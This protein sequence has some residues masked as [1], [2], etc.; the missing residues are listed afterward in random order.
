LPLEGYEHLEYL[1]EAITDGWDSWIPVSGTT[2]TN[3]VVGR[4]T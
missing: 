3:I 4:S 1:V 2:D